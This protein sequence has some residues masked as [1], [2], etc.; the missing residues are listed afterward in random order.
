MLKRG[1]WGQKQWN[2]ELFSHLIQSFLYQ[3]HEETRYIIMVLCPAKVSNLPILFNLCFTLLP[4]LP[5]EKYSLSSTPSLLLPSMSYF[6]LP[7]SSLSSLL[8]CTHRILIVIGERNKV[9]DRN[10]QNLCH[11]ICGYQLQV[12]LKF[13]MVSDSVWYLMFNS[14]SLRLVVKACF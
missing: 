9:S 12:S 14:P 1:G 3:G 6:L 13:L 5:S 7:L 2:P 10:K 4:S 11:P 8:L